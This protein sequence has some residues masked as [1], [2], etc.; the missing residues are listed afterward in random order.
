MVSLIIYNVR[1]QVVKHL[2]SALQSAGNYTVIWH[3]KDESGQM[4]PTG[5][6]LYRI[7]V[8]EYKASKKM[9]LME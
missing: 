3:G 7:N 6:Y 1:G 8:N 5:M 9:M 2:V 4:V